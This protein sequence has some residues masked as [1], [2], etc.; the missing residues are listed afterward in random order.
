MRCSSFTEMDNVI[1]EYG[2]VKPL[3]LTPRGHRTYEF[4]KMKK[5]LFI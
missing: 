1:E 3:T 2:E 5:I 4:L